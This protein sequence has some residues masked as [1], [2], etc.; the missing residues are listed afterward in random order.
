MQHIHFI[1]STNYIF[2]NNQTVFLFDKVY[3]V[4]RIEGGI[5]Y[6]QMMRVPLYFE[7][8]SELYDL[9]F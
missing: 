5:V 8:L 3:Y 4:F 6:H 9:Y 2:H 7:L 1:H